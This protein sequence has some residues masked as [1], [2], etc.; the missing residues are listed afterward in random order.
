MSAPVYSHVIY[1]IVPGEQQIVNRPDIVIVEGLNVLQNPGGAG[2][3][4]SDYF[5]FKIYVDAEEADIEAWYVERFLSLCAH[6]VPG[7]GVVLPPISRI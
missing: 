3:L 1:D 4:V 6:G 7:R 5:D 2:V